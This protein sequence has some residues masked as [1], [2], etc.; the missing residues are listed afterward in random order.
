MAAIPLPALD[1]RPP[2]APP[3]PLEQYGQLMQIQNMKNQ[4]SLFPLQ[5]QA[6]QTA[7]QGG[8]MELQQKQIALNDQKAMSAAMR[9]WGSPPAAAGGGAAGTT[10]TPGSGTPA[11]PGATKPGPGAAPAGAGPDYNDLV[12]LA[13]KNGASINA[14]MG[15]RQHVLEMQST[16]STIVKNDAQAGTAQLEQ[17]KSRNGQVADGLGTVLSSSDKELPQA[18]LNWAQ[19]AQQNGLID[20]QHLQMAQQIAQSG[21]P[22]AI[23][24]QVDSYRKSIM[25][26]S[27]MLDTAQKQYQVQ[28][29]GAGAEQALNAQ[30]FRQANPGAGPGG[31]VTPD[32]MQQA[33]FMSK[34]P[35]AGP[36]DFVLDKLKHSPMA[37]VMGNMFS[38]NDPGLDLA[39]NNYRMTGQMPAGMTRSPGTT[40]AIIDRAAAIDNQA[41]GEGIAGNKALLKSYSDALNKLQTNYSQVQAFEGTAERNMDLLQST[42]KGIPDLGS[43]FANIPA[44]AIT[45][46]MIGTANMAS[47]KTAL[48]TA[49]TEAAKVL[50]SSNATGVLSD[51]ARH[52]LQLIID[53][54]AP[55][56]AIIASLNTLKQD[57]GNRTQSYQMQIQD[58]QGKIKGATAAPGGAPQP[59]GQGGG[60]AFSQFGGVAH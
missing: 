4:Q 29:A 14:I 17:V 1:V 16:A 12:P 43:R 40:K 19:E 32:E 46:D 60:N 44:R 30:A 8:Q 10:P 56:P 52:E 9:E 54:N 15:L 37:M 21:D 7:V 3:S 25:G 39:A 6:A 55:V 5:E 23:R 26:F 2:A 38:P 53:G 42:L 58:L 33:D 50:N 35:G 31:G 18:L 45:G 22:N 13:I 47:F 27:Q 59:G 51:S 41:G 36:Y 48:N 11:V 28:T 24:S 57:M 49:Q 34:H 20:P